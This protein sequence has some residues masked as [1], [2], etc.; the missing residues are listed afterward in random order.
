MKTNGFTLI[1]LVVSVAVASGLVAVA[2]PAYKIHIAKT[3]AAEAE[4]LI[5]GQ[6]VYL[7]ANMQKG[8]CLAPGASDTQKGR[9]GTLK[10]SGSFVPSKGESCDSGCDLTYTLNSDVSKLIAGKKVTVDM[11]LN[12]EI[13]KNNGLT[14]IDPKF[15]TSSLTRAGAIA[16]G[17]NCAALSTA[18]PQKTAAVATSGNESAAAAPPGLKDDGSLDIDNSEVDKT[19]PYLPPKVDHPESSGKP[20]ISSCL[21]NVYAGI[22]PIKKQG[23]VTFDAATQKTMIL[24]DGSFYVK[25]L[26]LALQHLGRYYHTKSS[27]GTKG[28]Q[29]YLNGNNI[30]KG[31]GTSYAVWDYSNYLR[32]GWNTVH[33]EWGDLHL[34]GPFLKLVG[35][36][37][38]ADMR[39]GI[40]PTKFTGNTTFDAATNKVRV[41]QDGAFWIDNLDLAME[42]FGPYYKTLASGGVKGAQGYLNGHNIWKGK[43]TSTSVDDY[44]HLLRDGWN[45]VH[46]EWGELHIQGPFSQ[47]VKV[48]PGY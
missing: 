7:M 48:A 45:T 11:R 34:Q 32:N 12:G 29:G 6:R 2:A 42:Q 31:K 10:V 26:D 30:W 39:A 28:A 14:T 4:K 35:Y 37:N 25:N 17:D 44:S 33:M 36:T 41:V 40:D 15:L 3:Q 5:N 23:S 16:A 43:G 9:F 22:D 38:C 21:M 47:R 27:G 46:M 1:E 13:T 20:V 8:Y 24:M 18:E 19:V